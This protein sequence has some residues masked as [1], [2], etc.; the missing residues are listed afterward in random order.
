[1]SS[2]RVMNSPDR[3]DMATRSL[4]RQRLASWT[5]TTSNASA[6]RPRGPNGPLHPRNV[7]VVVGAPYVDDPIE[8][9]LELVEVIG[10][11]G[12]EVGALSVGPDQHAVLFVAVRRGVEPERSVSLV[13]FATLAQD[14]EGAWDGP[15]GDERALGEPVVEH[16][17]ETGQIV[18]DPAQDVGEH[19]IGHQRVVVLSEGGPGRR[20]EGVEVRILALGGRR[21]AQVAAK[22][23][24]VLPGQLPGHVPDVLSLVAAAGERRAARPVDNLQVAQPYAESQ[25]VHLAA[26]VVH[27]VLAF[28]VPAHRLE[29][30]G[31]RRTAGRAA[32]VSDVERTG[33]VDRHELHL[34]P[35]ARKAPRSA[36]RGPRA[37]DLGRDALKGFVRHREVDEAG[38]GHRG[39]LQVA[40]GR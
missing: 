16:H 30:I 35:P 24:V 17:P 15:R 37:D 38:A 12:G 34:H 10:D 25:D 11:V 23:N 31:H 6:S 29:Q 5:I 13:G 9:S 20:D 32:P 22:P 27:V 1:M 40:R 18:A 21:L 2:R 36:P 26:R 33:R 39:R 8:S 14:L 3:V 7:A 19:G 4:P 28:D